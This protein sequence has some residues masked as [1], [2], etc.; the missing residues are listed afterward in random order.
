MTLGLHDL[1]YATLTLTRGSGA[2]VIRNFLEKRNYA[3]LKN[4]L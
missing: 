3:L 1:R 4:A 2:G